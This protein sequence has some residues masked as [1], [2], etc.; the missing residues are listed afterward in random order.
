[1]F[2]LHKI[3]VYIKAPSY[4]HTFIFLQIRPSLQHDHD[5]IQEKEF[6]LIAVDKL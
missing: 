1:M 5:R 4:G 3:N 6:Y 2:F